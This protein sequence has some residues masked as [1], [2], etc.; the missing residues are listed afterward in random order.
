MK[1]IQ[2]RLRV[3]IDTWIR[4]LSY[5]LSFPPGFSFLF[6]VLGYLLEFTYGDLLRALVDGVWLVTTITP[7]RF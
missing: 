4:I 3:P 2:K 7:L 5:L 1:R 6:D